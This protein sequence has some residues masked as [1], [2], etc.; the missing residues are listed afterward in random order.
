MGTINN[1]TKFLI[2]SNQNPASHLTQPTHIPLALLKQPDTLSSHSSNIFQHISS[3]CANC[4]G[5]KE[6]RACLGT[7]HKSQ[8][9]VTESYL[10]ISRQRQLVANCQPPSGEWLAA[11]LASVWWQVLRC[12]RSLK[13]NKREQLH[14]FRPR[15]RCPS[16]DTTPS[17][18]PRP[19][20]LH[21][22]QNVS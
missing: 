20:A 12:M 21:R 11:K 2:I 15:D 13:F 14:K 6:P 19:Q 3:A 1:L 5:G 8:L 4:R 10:C 17:A 7:S 18:R 9:A 22:D 16:P